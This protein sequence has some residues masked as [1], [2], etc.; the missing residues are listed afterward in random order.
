VTKRQARKFALAIIATDDVSSIV[1]SQIDGA[2][3]RLNFLTAEDKLKIMAAA[4]DIAQW[5][6]NI[7]DEEVID[8][9]VGK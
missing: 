4:N 5:L 6:F 3:P 1:D 2:N 9:V 7:A 8:I